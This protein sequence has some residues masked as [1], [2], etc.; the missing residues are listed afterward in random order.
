MK[1]IAKLKD[2]CYR[3]FCTESFWMEIPQARDD[4][5]DEFQ[6]HTRSQAQFVF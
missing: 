2:L 6:A 3:L 4:R 5:G 1:I